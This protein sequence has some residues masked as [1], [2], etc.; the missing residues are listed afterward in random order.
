VTEEGGWLDLL[1][2]LALYRMRRLIRRPV[3]LALGAGIAAVYAFFS[4]LQG[5]MLVV[6]PATSGPLPPPQ[7]FWSG[8]PWW[9]FPAIL[10]VEP[11]WALYLPLLLTVTMLFAAAGVGLGMAVAV[12]LAVQLIRR[13]GKELA[14]PTALGSLAGLTPAMIGLLLLGAC[15]SISVGAIAGI[16]TVA[17]VSGSNIDNV[18]LNSW[19]LGL[20]ELGVLY[21]ALVAQEELLTVYGGLFGFGPALGL[22][23]EEAARRPTFDR[24]AAVAAVGRVA[25]VAGGLTWILSMSTYWFEPTW[26]GPVPPAPSTAL[27]LSFLF[28]HLV[29]GGLA[30]G[31]AFFPT[32]VHRWAVRAT[33]RARIARGVL[34]VSGLSLLAWLPAPIASAGVVG[35]PNEILGQF[36]APAAW[37]GILPPTLGPVALAFR[38]GVQYGLLGA[39]ALA[40]ALAPARVSGAFLGGSAAGRASGRAPTAQPRATPPPRPSEGIP[41]DVSATSLDRSAGT[42][43]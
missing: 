9:N 31:V 38:W 14:Q 4:M 25:L 24:R 22:T 42:E 20:F 40:L 41:A 36:G 5:G 16:G 29:P 13:R 43:A 37:G 7:L 19:Y 11:T 33:G 27:W 18:L 26:F 12:R 23:A 30:L 39:L 21:A 35:L 2:V 8:A 15:C 6:Y 32:R 3:Y 17:Q 28:Q 10:I 1:S 34:L